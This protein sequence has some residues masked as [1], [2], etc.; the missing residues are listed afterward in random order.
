M[1]VQ[2]GYAI[3][4]ERAIDGMVVD[5][6]VNNSVS[7]VNNTVAVVPYGIAVARD[8]ESG[9]VLLTNASVIADVVGVTRRELNK[10]QRDGDADGAQPARDASVLTV[11]TIYVRVV[12][13]VTAG[14]PAFVVIGDGS[15]PATVGR[16]SAAAG[17]LATTAL[18]L[19]NA[20]FITGA[21]DGELAAL[22]IVTG[23]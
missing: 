2:G 14:Q 3:D 17:T 20:K 4:H 6:Q 11:G 19:P 22:S 1:A 9:F 18:A 13:T 16:F 5:S 23:G 15:N 10:A 8:G 21:A 12:G 7:K